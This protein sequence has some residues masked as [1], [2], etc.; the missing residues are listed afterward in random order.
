MKGFTNNSNT[1]ANQASNSKKVVPPKALAQKTRAALAQALT[2]QAT[3]GSLNGKG[4]NGQ[5]P[6]KQTD[7]EK[8][9]NIRLEDPARK[10]LKETI[11]AIGQH[12]INGRDGAR[13]SISMDHDHEEHSTHEDR[14]TS[15]SSD[16]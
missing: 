7:E 6:T 1:D 4:G 2:G 9:I 10:V 15:T 13:L 12:S 11:G 16:A 5:T 14:K 8:L 3:K